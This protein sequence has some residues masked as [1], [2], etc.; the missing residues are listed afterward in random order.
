VRVRFWILER[1]V[2]SALKGRTMNWA[3]A[4]YDRVCLIKLG[5]EGEDEDMDTPLLNN[6][7]QYSHH[8]LRLL[9]R[10]PLIL[11]SLHKLKR[12]E[13]MVPPLYCCCTKGSGR[14]EAN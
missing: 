13:M 6:I 2:S 14:A 7:T 3:N 8:S 1:N 4:R 12:I 9:L 10:K 5:E 11:E